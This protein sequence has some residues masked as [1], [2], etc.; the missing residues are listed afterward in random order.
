MTKKDISTDFKARRTLHIFASLCNTISDG[1]PNISET[2]ILWAWPTEAEY[3]KGLI[4][5][6]HQEYKRNNINP[7]TDDYLIKESGDPDLPY[8][9]IATIKGK[10]DDKFGM[11]PS[12]TDARALA[13]AHNKGDHKSLKT[14]QARFNTLIKRY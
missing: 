1:L 7:P 14:M 9:V 4:N 10:K 6:S 3:A 13:N 5:I 2:A 12:L 8:K 11:A